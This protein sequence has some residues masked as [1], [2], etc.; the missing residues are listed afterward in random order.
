MS[1]IVRM[2]LAL[3]ISAVDAVNSAQQLDIVRITL[4]MRVRALQ[5]ALWIA[6][7]EAQSVAP[8]IDTSGLQDT[9]TVLCSTVAILARRADAES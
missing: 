7:F 2:M 9:L 6:L 8:E 5:H 3:P 1:G 4:E